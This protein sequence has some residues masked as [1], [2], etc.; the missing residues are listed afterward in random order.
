MAREQ[1]IQ[2][3]R[4]DMLKLSAGGAGMFMVGAGG[5][6]IP[7]SVAGGGSL[8]IEAF[9]TSPL[10]LTP[11]NDPL[12][13][14]DALRPVDPTT[15]D[16]SGGV[17]DPANQDSMGP[18]PTTD[19]YNKYGQTLGTH[20]LWPGDGVTANYPWI[21]R[22][23]LVYQLKLQVAGHAFTSSQVQPINSFGKIVTPPG[24]PNSN[25]RALP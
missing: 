21:S 1:K 12:N 5:F 18:S 13:I 17:P 14:P 22:K 2:L 4:R 9:P 24:S 6:A 10:I 25:P 20:Q 15:W 8:Y 23:P 16:S 3:T 7:R 11:F 19:Y